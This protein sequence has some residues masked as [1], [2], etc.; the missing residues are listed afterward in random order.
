[1]EGMLGGWLEEGWLEEGWLGD[2]LK[3]DCREYDCY[4]VLRTSESWIS[5]S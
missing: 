1:M 4:S 5:N 2:G 3:V